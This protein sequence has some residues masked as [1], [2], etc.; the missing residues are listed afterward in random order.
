[1]ECRRTGFSTQ[2]KYY[3]NKKGTVA[4]FLTGAQQMKCGE[5]LGEAA[6]KIIVAKL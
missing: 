4:L 1:M 3:P 5:R 6:F 2:L